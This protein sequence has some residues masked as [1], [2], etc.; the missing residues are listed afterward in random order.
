MAETIHVE[1]YFIFLVITS[2][3]VKERTKENIV[4]LNR[5]SGAAF[6]GIAKK[7]VTQTEALFIQPVQAVLPYFK[8]GAIGVL[9]Q[10]KYILKELKV[11]LIGLV[12]IP[13]QNSIGIVPDN[14]GNVYTSLSS[15]II[16]IGDNIQVHILPRRSTFD[17]ICH[18]LNCLG[19]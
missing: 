14:L 11:V 5:L 1:V 13:F 18:T 3:R 15:Q 10:T 6:V 7:N 4:L 9:L 16:L 8:S 19:Q 2:N 17:L 12:V